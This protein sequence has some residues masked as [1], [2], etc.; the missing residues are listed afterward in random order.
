MLAE[1]GFLNESFFF[2][3]EETEFCARAR[4]SGYRVAAAP[5]LRTVHRLGASSKRRAPLATRI[6]YH[7]SL[8]RYYGLEKGPLLPVAARCARALR[9]AATLA[10]LGPLYPFS[11]A[12]ARAFRGASRAASMASSRL[13]GSSESCGIARVGGR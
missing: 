2:F 8:Y 6:E 4:R 11:A 13:P 7:R 10:L 1:V 3:L 5:A 12:Q 9:G